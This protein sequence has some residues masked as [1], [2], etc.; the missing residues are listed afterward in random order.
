MSLVVTPE[1]V[2]EAEFKIKEAKLLFSLCQKKQMTK[3]NELNEKLHQIKTELQA[4]DT[5]IKPYI[6]NIS[7]EE[8]Y[9]QD[10]LELQSFVSRVNSVK[11]IER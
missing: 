3:R 9:L 6:I 8:Q 10:L 4:L 7:V 1:E 11:K 2:R 5:E